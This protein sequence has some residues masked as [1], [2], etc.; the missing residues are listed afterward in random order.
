MLQ[1]PA[2][3]RPPPKEIEPHDLKGKK[4]LIEV[5]RSF[6]PYRLPDLMENSSDF[7]FFEAVCECGV[8]EDRL[9]DGMEESSGG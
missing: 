1:H 3:R 5:A 8:L 7:F 6:L 4:K 9:E 2:R